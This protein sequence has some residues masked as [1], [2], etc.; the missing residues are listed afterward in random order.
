MSDAVYVV[1]F[2]SISQGVGVLDR[3][4]KRADVELLYA[5]AICVGK[6]LICVGGDVADA[7]EAKKAAE[8]SDADRPLSSCLLTGTHPDIRGY[9]RKERPEVSEHVAA[10][11][12]FETR[13]AASGFASLDCALKS[14]QVRPLKIW[15]GHMLGG[16]FCYV[17]GGSTSDIQSAI[18]RAAAAVPEKER[19]GERVI[20]SPDSVTLGL[21]LRGHGEER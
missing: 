12:L 6:Y 13:H 14:A 19:V 5:N 18:R 1:E 16:K 9:F 8:E 3:M 7:G 15:L 17:L 2:S 10:I 4:L 20:P 21:F 11:G